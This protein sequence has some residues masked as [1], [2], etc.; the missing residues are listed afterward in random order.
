MAFMYRNIFV[1]GVGVDPD[2]T[3][4]EALGIKER[5]YS[6]YDMKMQ[7]IIKTIAK[8]ETG[9]ILLDAIASTGKHLLI[10]PYTPSAP[11][12]TVCNATASHIPGS[13]DLTKILAYRV[14]TYD[15]DATQKGKTP[16]NKYGKPSGGGIGTGRGVNST[17][18]FSPDTWESG[19]CGLHQTSFLPHAVMFHEMVHAYRHMKGRRNRQAT[20]SGL[21]A[22]ANDEE[23]FAVVLSNIYISDPTTPIGGERVLRFG[24]GNKVMPT[25]ESTT[26]GFLGNP[27]NQKMVEK[28]KNQ[29]PELAGALSVV[30]CDF[31][32]FR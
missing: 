24:H 10:T 5:N 30:K 4:L 14:G 18:N 27:E 8:S 7:K 9:K 22:Y 6:D 32:P 26:K 19:S 16:L 2:P 1:N 29:E 25:T 31:N 23:Y 17:I 21:V 20:N 13:N 3:F 28:L 12:Q 11:N 15:R